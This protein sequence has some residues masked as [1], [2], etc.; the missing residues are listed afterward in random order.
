MTSDRLGD[1]QPSD[2]PPAPAET[3]ARG[4]PEVGGAEADSR[5]P[6]SRP[7]RLETLL[8]LVFWAVVTVIVW[9]LAVGHVSPRRFQD[10]FL[11]SSVAESIARGEW[12][13]W[14]GTGLGIKSPLYPLLVA[15]AYLLG[16]S[17]ETVYHSIHLINAAMMSAVIFPVYF[18]GR[19]YLEPTLAFTAALFAVAAPGMNY[20]GIIGT[21]ALAY[22]AAAFACL[23]IAL[24]AAVPSGRRWAL[25]GTAIALAILTRTQFVVFVPILLGAVLLSGWMRG[26]DGRRAYFAEQRVALLAIGAL[27]AVGTLFALVAPGAAV[28]LYKEALEGNLPQFDELWFWLRA[29][30]ADVFVVGGIIPVI[31]AI[32]MAFQRENRRHP[33]IGALLATALVA[34]AGFVA[35][36]AWFSANNEFDWRA[37]HIFYERYMF[38][39]GPLFFVIFMTCWRRIRPLHV[40]WAMSIAA[41]TMWAGLHSDLVLVPFS[42]DAFGLTLAGWVLDSHPDLAGSLGLLAAALTLLM[43]WVLVAASVDNRSVARFGAAGALL[44]AFTFLLWNQ[45]KTWEYARLYSPIAFQGVPKP[46]DWIDR[47][48]D[49]DVGMIVTSTDAPEMYFS[50][51]FWNRRITRA[52]ATDKPPISSPVMYSPRCEFDWAADGTILGTGCDAVPRAFYVRSNTVAVHL[53]DPALEYE[54]SPDQRLLIA[55]PPVRLLS[56]LAGRDVTTGVAKGEV[57]LW[58]FADRGGVVRMRVRSLE[59]AG[60][61]RVGRRTFALP[62]RGSAEIEFPVGKGEQVTTVRFVDRLALA[63]EVEIGEVELSQPGGEARD[64][65]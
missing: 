28:G 18:V 34:S 61:V 51:E 38:Y 27:L 44:L 26:P 19:R 48:T 64:L 6:V 36:V 11:W 46:V 3:A 5:L 30:T 58:T 2:Q 10:E 45:A 42:Y 31:A 37:R 12:L 60:K 15:P 29:F 24:V 53:Q 57:K 43:G 13:S 59:G 39:L 4:R 16:G 55:R 8:V 7:S 50:S 21:E 47:K 1:Q 14:R 32:A 20:A 33:M 49:R 52:F 35:E 22:P 62:R 17:T 25:A 23:A 63:I 40:I 9:R 41:L 54:K 65:G 56:M